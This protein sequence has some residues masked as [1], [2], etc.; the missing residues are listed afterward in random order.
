MERLEA[1]FSQNIAI[2]QDREEVVDCTRGYHVDP[3][4]FA[5]S[6]PRLL[7]QALA[8]IRPFTPEVRPTVRYSHLMGH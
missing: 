4:T 8:L 2:T 3:I 5:T 7:N 6:K 1:D